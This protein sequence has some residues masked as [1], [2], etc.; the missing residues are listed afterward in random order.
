MSAGTR[1][2]PAVAARVFE[3]LFTTKPAGLGTGLGLPLCRMIAETHGGRIDL[4]TLPGGGA[5]ATVWLPLEGNEP[6]N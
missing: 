4:A 3:P 1:S 6:V 5:C 2:S